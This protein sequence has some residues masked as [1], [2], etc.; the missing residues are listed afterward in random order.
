MM[1]KENKNNELGSAPIGKL[2]LKMAVPTVMAQLVNLLYGIVDRIYV[3][4]IPGS[5]SF[6]LAGLG[7]TFPILM[8]ISAFGAL[9]GMGGAPRAAIA[10]G[11][12]DDKKAGLILGNSVTLLLI[13]SVLLTVV[14]SFTKEPIL[15]A[16]GASENILPYASEYISVYLIGTIFVLLTLGLNVF[17]TTQGFAAASMMTVCIGC[18][19]NII[20]DPIFIFTLNMGVA[21]AA[22]ATVISQGVSAVWVVGFLCSRKSKLRIRFENMRLRLQIVGTTLAL[23]SSAFVM[24]ATECAVQLVF[25][26]G[27]QTYGNDMY[28]ALMSIMF[29]LTQIVWLPLMGVGQGAQ[30]IISYN[31][32]AKNMQ[33]V[34]DTIKTLVFVCICFSVVSVGAILIFPNAFIG[35]FTPDAE[36]I[37]IGK[38]PLRIFICGMLMMGM[39]SACQQSFLALGQAKDS[40]IM[41]LLRKVIL[42]LPLALVLP[43]VFGLGLWGLFIAE[44]ISDVIASIVTTVTFKIK[45]RKLLENTGNPQET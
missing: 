10:M 14:F 20:L 30:P 36:L 43:G 29:S 2:L 18:V 31:Y 3:G 8:L 26:K 12:K 42:L 4:R 45:S 28:V 24:Q 44:P 16:F 21:G 41:A 15:R 38:T 40:M 19:L 11:E 6:A 35:L 13:F 7:V 25:N 27:M 5:G 34:K 32:G 23:G 22:V 37:A 39:Q 33:R 9:V 17:I 1:A